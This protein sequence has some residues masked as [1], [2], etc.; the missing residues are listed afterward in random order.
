MSPAAQPRRGR[1]AGSEALP[2]EAISRYLEAFIEMLIV[3]LI[4]GMRNL[5]SARTART[6][7]VLAS[8]GIADP[9]QR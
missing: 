9:T 5:G 8:L 7:N 6:G 2:P 4:L 3:L 1:A